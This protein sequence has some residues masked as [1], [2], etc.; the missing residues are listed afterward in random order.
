MKSGGIDAVGPV[1]ARTKQYTDLREKTAVLAKD[2]A[3]MLSD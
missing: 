1:M 2:W 3:G